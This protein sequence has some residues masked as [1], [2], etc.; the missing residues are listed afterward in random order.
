MK[1]IMLKDVIL[2]IRIESY[3]NQLK[4]LIKVENA[5]GKIIKKYFDK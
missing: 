4:N 2:H 1:W 3:I 5:E